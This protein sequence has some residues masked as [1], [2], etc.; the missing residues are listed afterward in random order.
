MA[1]HLSVRLPW[2]DR[3]WDGHVCDRPTANVFCTGEYGLKAHGIREGKRDNEEEAQCSQPCASMRADGYRPP[4]LRTIQ[5]FGGT[6]VLPFQHEPKSFLST[7]DNPIR[8]V[9]EG[10]KPFTVGTWAYD[11]VFRREE[12]DDEVPEE[13]AERYSPESLA[14]K[15]LTDFSPL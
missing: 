8:S 7:P 11:Q 2:H 4:C 12:A 10:I 14:E 5:T 9:D 1:K 13:F 15:E 3:G 6:A